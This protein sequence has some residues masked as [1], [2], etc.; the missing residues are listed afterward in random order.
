MD[1]TRTPER[2]FLTTEEV[3]DWLRRP[4]PTL[5]SWRC[6]GEGPPWLKLAGNVVYST[7]EVRTWIESQKVASRERTAS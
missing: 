7:A 2:E 6:R 1:A 3:A 4:V 5:K